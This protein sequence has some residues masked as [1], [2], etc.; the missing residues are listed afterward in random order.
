[1]GGVKVPKKFELGRGDESLESLR[2]LMR[3]ERKRKGWS[4]EKIAKIMG[5]SPAYLSQ[6]ENS[7]RHIYWELWIVWCSA[8]SISPSYLVD[9]WMRVGAFDRFDKKR[10]LEYH[11]SIDQMIELGFSKELENL[12]LYFTGLINQEMEARRKEHK[13]ERF[14][15]KFRKGE[16]KGSSADLEKSITTT[17]SMEERLSEK[18]FI[19]KAIERLRQPRTKEYPGIHSVDSGFNEAWEKYYG[20]DPMDGIQRLIFQGE[21]DIRHVKDGIVIYL[22]GEAPGKKALDIILE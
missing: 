21:V 11:K 22:P 15:D 17:N 13:K 14:A 10:K 8:L 6:L 7:K 16:G 5:I 18:G 9:K 19:Y 20:T 2:K 4:Q 3:S 12:M 1:V